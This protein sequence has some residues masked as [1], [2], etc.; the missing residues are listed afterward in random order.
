MGLSRN[1][2]DGLEQEAV[3]TK[4]CQNYMLALNAEVDV[5]EHLP[6]FAATTSSGFA[7]EPQVVISAMQR[8]NHKGLS[9]AFVVGNLR[10]R[11]PDG[12]EA[13]IRTKQRVVKE[14][15][16]LWRNTQPRS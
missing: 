9:V 10:F 11:S 3:A 1:Q 4:F 8:R 15:L 7:C 14:A 16:C 6:P 12:K 5:I 2:M 13:S